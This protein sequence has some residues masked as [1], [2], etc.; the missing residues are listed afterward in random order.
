MKNKFILF[1]P[2]L[3]KSPVIEV[4]ERFLVGASRLYTDLWLMGSRNRCVSSDV[5]EGITHD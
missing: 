5:L 1:S 4:Y 2:W 3:L